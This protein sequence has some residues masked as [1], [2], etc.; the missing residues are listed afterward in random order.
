MAPRTDV[1]PRR[2]LPLVV[3]ADVDLLDDLLRLAAAGGTEVGAATDP[4]AARTRWSPAPLVLVGG[5]QAQPCLRARLPRRS[6]LVL[7]GRTGLA[8]PGWEI[9]EL[10]GAEHVAILPAA[11]P[12]LVD[13]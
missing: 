7:V 4:A 5:D 11:E 12:W 9:A 2:R 3:T 13:R 1:R 6:R 10:I 8:D